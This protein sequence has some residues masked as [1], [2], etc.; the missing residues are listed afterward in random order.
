LDKRSNTQGYRVIASAIACS[1]ALS[2]TSIAWAQGK[3]AS[4]K[5]AAPAAAPAADAPAKGDLAAAKKHYA[6]GEK[7]YK[8]GDY[9]GALA[10]FKEANDIKST[11]HAER[12][13]ALCE[14]ALGHYPAAVEW[15]EKFLGHVPDKLASQGDEAKKRVGEIKAMPGKVHV[16]S[17]PAGAAIT[18][19]DK[20]APAPGLT[21]AD[22]ELPPGPHT[23]KLTLAG[24]TAASKPLDVAY[25]A[26]QTLTVALEAEPAALPRSLEL[27]SHGM[28]A[29][30]RA[31]AL[32]SGAGIAFPAGRLVSTLEEAQRAAATLGFPVVLKA[33]SADLPHKSDA[34]G[35][36]LGLSDASSL[37]QG[38]E[39][40]QANMA[41]N[42]PGLQLDGVLVEAMGR[43]G[44][45]L[46]IGG[47]HD[48]E[49]GPI[50][51]AGFGGIQAEILQD[52]CL[53]VP[54]L[55]TETIVAELY[56]LKSGALLRGFRGSPAL[57][58]VAVAE[59]IRRVGALLQAQPSIQEID[60]NPVVVYP[61]GQGA[62]AL[63]A[64]MQIQ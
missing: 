10:E 28:V 5:P 18:V 57:D 44:V 15:Y 48:P 49:W 58:V 8:A 51:L 54:G 52:V 64:L 50:V 61:V 20:P 59:I 36:V 39:Q 14:D 13:I 22:L 55:P 2:S 1:L 24:Y 63:D 53:L 60:L 41:K 6:D 45:E 30:Y 3:P 31:K 56:G 38:W 42:R 62:V 27:P 21:P 7:K 26:T 34:G 17:T 37:A 9:A 11:P 29:E 33:Q 19:D 43:R 25:A 16:D 40:L 4:P 32:L 35:V 46:I 23:V 47:R 12:Y